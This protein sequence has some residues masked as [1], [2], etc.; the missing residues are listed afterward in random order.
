MKE[1]N[2]ITPTDMK[3][4][5]EEAL[6]ANSKLSLSNLLSWLSIIAAVCPILIKRLGFPYSYITLAVGLGVSIV[7]MIIAKIIC[8]NAK[9]ANS[10]MWIYLVFGGITIVYIVTSVISA[11]IKT[12][13]PIM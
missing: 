6:Q 1:K 11:S 2:N 3:K 5:K 4:L 10:I 12:G 9:L 7:L 8:K 13:T